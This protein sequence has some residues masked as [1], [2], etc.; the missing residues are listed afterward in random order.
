MSRRDRGDHNGHSGAHGQP[1][2][3]DTFHKDESFFHLVGSLVSDRGEHLDRT[4]RKLQEKKWHSVR[5]AA[6]LPRFYN[7]PNHAT[8]FEFFATL[9]LF[10]RI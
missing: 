7:Q 1:L 10:P 6:A 5:Q 2:Q 4:P 9:H 3:T 8:F